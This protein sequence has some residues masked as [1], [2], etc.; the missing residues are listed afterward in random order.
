MKVDADVFDRSDVVVGEVEVRPVRRT[1]GGAGGLRSLRGL[2]R[3]VPDARRG[4]GRKHRL[5]TVLSIC[6]RWRGWPVRR[7][8]SGSR[9]TWTGKELRALGAWRDPAAGR[10]V[11][12]SDSPST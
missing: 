8:R 4:Q 9:G 12:P 5:K 3:E 2:F 11:T 10:R 1:G 6:A 7:R